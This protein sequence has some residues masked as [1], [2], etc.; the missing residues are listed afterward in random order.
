MEG[1]FESQNWVDEA[2]AWY[3]WWNEDDANYEKVSSGKTKHREWVK[4]VYNPDIIDYWKLVELFWTQIDPTDEGGQFADRWFQYTTA[5]YYSNEEEKIIAINSKKSLEESKKFDKQIA[6]SILEFPSF[7][8]AEEYHQDYYKKSSFRY[9]LYKKWSWRSKYIEENRWKELKELSEDDLKSKLTPLQY[10]VTKENWTERAFDNEYRDN[11]MPWIYVDI[12]DWTP[13][14]SSID[15][16]ESWTGWPSFTKPIDSI[17]LELLEDNTLFSKRTE[18]RSKNSDSHLWHVFDDWPTDKWWLR[19]CL[20][21]A[22]L[23]FIWVED[24]EDEWY[25]EYKILFK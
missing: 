18:V 25:W 7:F 20:N 17:N 8:E 19:Y 10:K 11:K 21:S 24:L 1:I 15:K 4:I 6:T 9:N 14:F 3:I 12:I 16:Y 13:L 22:S 5:I 23:R 2:I